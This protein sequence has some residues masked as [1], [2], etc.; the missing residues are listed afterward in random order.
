MHLQG[1]V[2]PGLLALAM[3]AGVAVTAARLRRVPDLEDVRV[4]TPRPALVRS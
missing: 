3:L 1:M 4:L 2:R